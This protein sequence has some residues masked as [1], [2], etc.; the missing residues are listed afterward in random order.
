MFLFELSLASTNVVVKLKV[1][2]A[3]STAGMISALT[4]GVQ[5]V[6]VELRT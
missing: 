6:F 1:L 4:L 5:P 3:F 2:V